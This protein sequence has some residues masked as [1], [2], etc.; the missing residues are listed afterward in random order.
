[1][2][3][4][5]SIGQSILFA[6]AGRHGPVYW[7]DDPSLDRF[8][9]SGRRSG[10]A[11][12]QQYQDSYRN[13]WV[14]SLATSHENS[15]SYGYYSNILSSIECSQLDFDHPLRAIFNL[16]FITIT[17]QHTH[18]PRRALLKSIANPDCNCPD[19]SFY[20]NRYS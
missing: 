18:F 11:K 7:F 15:G 1:M 10:G 19:P 16:Y 5:Q 9:R 12:R 4:K 20:S 14:I 3:G 13:D 17:I 8:G 2:K 6:G